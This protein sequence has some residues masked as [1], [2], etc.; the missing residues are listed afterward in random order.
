MDLELIIFDMDGTLI[1]SEE[2]YAKGWLEGLKKYGFDVPKDLIRE[3]SGNSVQLN[4]KIIKDIVHSDELVQKIRLYRE[5]LFNYSV[6]KEKVEAIPGARELLESLSGK[7]TI[8][9]AT[10][11]HRKRATRILKQLDL[12]K[13]FD[14]LEF[15]DEISRQKP[16]PDV[17]LKIMQGC[18]VSANKTLIFEDSLNGFRAAYA[19]GAKTVLINSIDLRPLD[20]RNKTM[21]YQNYTSFRADYP[22]V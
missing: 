15:G 14:F 1:N 5:N 4:N 7:Y 17:Y 18:K 6:R 8:G 10:L 9:L 13:Y 16:Y 19:S 21:F 11:S 20:T 2:I 12:F 22:D 3:M